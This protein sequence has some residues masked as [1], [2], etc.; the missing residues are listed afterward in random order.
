MLRWGLSI[1]GIGLLLVLILD[2][3]GLDCCGDSKI[4][5]ALFYAYRIVIPVGPLLM[6]IGL[7]QVAIDRLRH[8]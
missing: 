1:F 3:A 2:I 4:M 7:V 5:L 6:L 8:R